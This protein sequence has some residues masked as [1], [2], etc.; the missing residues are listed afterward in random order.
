MENQGKCGPH[1][2]LFFFFMKKEQV[3]ASNEVLPNPCVSAETLK[4]CALIGLH[5]LATGY[6]VRSSGSQSLDLE[7]SGNTVVQKALTGM[8]RW[9]MDGKRRHFF[10]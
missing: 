5:L 3:V 4:T 6:E 9:V 10:F 1:G 8:Q 7:D 2:E